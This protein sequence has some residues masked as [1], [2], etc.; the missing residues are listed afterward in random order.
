MNISP[1]IRTQGRGQCA[2]VSTVSCT[3][4]QYK[5]EYAVFARSGSNEAEEFT[6]KLSPDHLED[7]VTAFRKTNSRKGCNT[8][9]YCLERM[10][11]QGIVTEEAYDGA[12]ENF[13][14]FQR[15]R[16]KGFED[17]SKANTIE[18][19]EKITQG[20]ALIGNFRITTDYYRLGPDDIYN[21]PKDAV[22][23]TNI[24]G[25]VCSHCVVILGYGVTPE[26]LSYYIFQNSYG[27]LW[28][29]DG[30]GRIACDCLKH[31]YCP[32]L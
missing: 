5:R 32:S 3:E 1:S 23:E 22:Y 10:Q 17:L 28:G 20:T 12:K 8:L 30:F 14:S 19:K 16:I 27:P 26:G 18:V 4:S 31:L 29:K 25:Q 11:A 7:L 15:Y 13:D 6:L 21:I 2:Y 24:M 9:D